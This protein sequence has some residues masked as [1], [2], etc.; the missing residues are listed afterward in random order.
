MVN[1]AASRAEHLDILKAL[2]IVS[3]VYGHAGGPFS[4]FVSLYHMAL[5]FFVSGYFYKESYTQAPLMLIKKRLM[6]LYVPFITFGVLFGLL[7]NVFYSINL[8]SDQVQSI[9][10][11]T[12]YF[13]T[14]REYLLNLV[15]ILSFA[16]VEQLLSPLW[17]LPVLF[18]VNMIFVSV[19]YAVFR[20][21][22]RTTPRRND[23]R[24][25][26]LMAVVSCA[27]FLYYPERNLFLR[28]VSIAMAVSIMF[29][30]GYLFRGIEKKVALKGGVAFACGIFLA[31]SSPFGPIDTGGHTFV[32]PPFYIACS[33]AGIYMNLYLATRLSGRTLLGRF[34][35]YT[36]RNTITILALHFLAFRMINYVQV[37][38]RGLPA[39][40][41]AQ[42]PTLDPSGG[43]WIAYLAAGVALPLA[44]RAAYDRVKQFLFEKQT[45]PTAA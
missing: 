7:H 28:P 19:N 37:V 9:Y 6:S 31:A 44:A 30:F 13:A 40:H 26:V 10:N 39:Y 1:D 8:Y 45:S 35:L 38:L 18:I 2:G 32:S 14:N 33:L 43:W 24:L 4:V 17:F 12:V 22:H 25:A 16:R 42:H 11:R 20:V 23:V 21:G 34:L 36:G 5:F 15:K 3:V 29:Y 41:T 27:G